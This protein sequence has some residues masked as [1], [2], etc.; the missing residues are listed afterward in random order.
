M[1]WIYSEQLNPC[2]SSSS[3][4]C[5]LTSLGPLWTNEIYSTERD[6][7]PGMIN[8]AQILFHPTVLPYSG[9]LSPFLCRLPL[10]SSRTLCLTFYESQTLSKVGHESMGR[11]C[12]HVAEASSISSTTVGSVCIIL[13][14]PKFQT[15]AAYTNHHNNEN[16]CMGYLNKHSNYTQSHLDLLTP[17]C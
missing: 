10:P 5:K 7:K 17:T 9:S 13:Y 2:A 15:T 8:G 12:T 16:V 14:F 1:A 3:Q 11:A 4:S 6:R